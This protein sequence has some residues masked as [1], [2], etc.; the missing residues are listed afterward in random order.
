MA[1]RDENNDKSEGH[2][3]QIRKRAR[4]CGVNTGGGKSNSARPW[5]D[6]KLPYECRRQY[7]T[8]ATDGDLRTMNPDIRPRFLLTAYAGV[9]SAEC[10][11]S[12]SRRKI[13]R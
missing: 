8:R 7:R 12:K 10:S 4:N 1:V 6:A 9:T 5:A 11:P 3:I 2:G 13:F